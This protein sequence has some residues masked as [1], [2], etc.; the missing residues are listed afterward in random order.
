MPPAGGAVGRISN[1]DTRDIAQFIFFEIAAQFE[2]YAER[3]FE[4]EVRSRLRV[5]AVQSRFVMGDADRG[6]DGKLGWGS[7]SLLHDRGINL[8][9]SASLFGTL[10][11]KLTQPICDALIAA[12]TVRNRI[13]HSG[14]AAQSKFIKHL[15]GPGIP[16]AQRMGM[17]VGR[18]LRDYPT[19]ATPTHRYFFIY[20]GAYSAF[21]A[22]AVAALP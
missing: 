5:T 20:L 4:A 19:T 1:A 10:D 2:E 17:S 22:Q 14:G 11:A 8:L 9:G 7:A 18:F 13:A 6:L 3:M 15:T 12:H 16:A 21:A